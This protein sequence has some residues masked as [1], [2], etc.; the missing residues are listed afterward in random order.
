MPKIKI[1]WLCH[2]TNT[3][4]QSLLP[5]WRKRQPEFAFWIPNMLKGFEMRE[6]I[7]IH[8]ISPHIYLKRSTNI[9]LRNI[10]YHFIP[11]GIP[12]VHLRWPKF[13]E[14]DIISNYRLYRKKVKKTIYK[15]QPDI[16]DLIGAENVFYSSSIL[17]FKNVYPISVTIQGFISQLKDELKSS[18][19]LRKG[20]LLKNK[21]SNLLNIMQVNRTLLHISQPIIQIM[22]SLSYM[23]L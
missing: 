6:D 14:F 2:F 13:F 22:F 5:L 8:V 9:K 12:L 18:F 10:H 16:I 4:V 11:L 15:I 3:E 23:G 7:E 19:E 1:V 17:D 20:S 21:Y